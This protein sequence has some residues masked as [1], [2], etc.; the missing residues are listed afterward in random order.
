M[1]SN[2]GL[3]GYVFFGKLKQKIMRCVKNVIGF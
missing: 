3:S 1:S 2:D